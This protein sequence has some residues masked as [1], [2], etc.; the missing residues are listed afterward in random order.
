MLVF[1]PGVFG[2]AFKCFSKRKSAL[3]VRYLLFLFA[4]GSDVYKRQ[5]F[6]L[7][8]GRIMNTLG[9]FVSRKVER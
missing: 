5:V 2:G 9:L 6:I 4:S 3:F 1:L 7:Q 8:F